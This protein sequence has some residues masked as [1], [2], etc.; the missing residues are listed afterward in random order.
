ME[1]PNPD[2]KYVTYIPPW[3]ESSRRRS[4][5][6]RRRS[7]HPLLYLSTGQSPYS[8][9]FNPWV[10]GISVFKE[11]LDQKF[12]EI[13]THFSAIDSAI[14]LHYFYIP[15]NRDETIKNTL[16]FIEQYHDKFMN[17]LF[18]PVPTKTYMEKHGLSYLPQ[19]RLR[20]RA[21]LYSY[22]ELGEIWYTLYTDFRTKLMEK[23][24]DIAQKMSPSSSIILLSKF[25]SPNST[26]QIIINNAIEYIE[27]NKSQFENGQIVQL[28]T[29]SR[30]VSPKSPRI[31]RTQSGPMY[32]N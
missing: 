13:G 7:V 18:F 2:I 26:E 9:L 32:W 29:S 10:E 28:P 15:N 20:R 25:Y 27:K 3:S 19:R 16:D 14:L 5:R 23:Y 12:P 21:G 30:S 22:I 4:P 24:P 17:P 1:Q 11:R 31:Q 6:R 8:I